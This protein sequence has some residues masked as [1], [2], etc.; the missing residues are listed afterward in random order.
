MF[1]GKKLLKIWL[2]VLAGILLILAGFVM[3]DRHRN[4]R[5]EGK[6]QGKA[7]VYMNDSWFVNIPFESG[8]DLSTEG[9][10]PVFSYVYADSL[11]PIFKTVNNPSLYFTDWVYH[12]EHGEPAM[13]MVYEQSEWDLTFTNPYADELTAFDTIDGTEISYSKREN[14]EF[15]VCLKKENRTIVMVFSYSQLDELKAVLEKAWEEIRM[16]NDQYEN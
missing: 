2:S 10:T 9:L 8:L 1:M 12:T 15:A 14:G 7:V 3:I 13:F 16:E 5:Y 11:N 6:Y 4:I